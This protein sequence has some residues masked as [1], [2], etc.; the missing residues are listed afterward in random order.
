MNRDICNLVIS[1]LVI[2]A[3]ESL[4]LISQ[5]SITL[6]ENPFYSQ[7]FFLITGVVCDCKVISITCIGFSGC[8]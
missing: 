1:Y 5:L 4:Q 7:Y 8:L 6:L 2:P 3:R